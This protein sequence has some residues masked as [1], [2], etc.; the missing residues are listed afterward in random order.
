MP[1][2]AADNCVR[3]V[4]SS[5]SGPLGMWDT[6]GRDVQAPDA[7]PTCSANAENTFLDPRETTVGKIRVLFASFDLSRSPSPHNWGGPMLSA[8]GGRRNRRDQLRL[9]YPDIAEEVSKP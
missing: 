5:L 8:P 1:A 9:L 7:D 6:A 2:R 4:T 3:L